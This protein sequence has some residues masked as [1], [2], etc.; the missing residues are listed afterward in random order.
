MNQQALA[1]W[2]KTRPECVQ[3][4]AEEFPLGSKFT[5]P[6]GEPLHLLGYTE[7]DELI[8]SNIDPTVDY[9]GAN[10]NKLYSCAGHYRSHPLPPEVD[11]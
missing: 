4:L 2:L 5:G 8:L 6:N 11:S 10:A 3:K 1:E 7:T 9:E